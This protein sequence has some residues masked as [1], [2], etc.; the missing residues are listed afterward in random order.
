MRHWTAPA[1]LALL[2]GCAQRSLPLPIS[3]VGLDSMTKVHFDSDPV[4]LPDGGQ[5]L[6]FMTSA[7]HSELRVLNLD[8]AL[9][10]RD[11]IR[12][13][14]PIEPLAIPVLPEP[15]ALAHDTTWDPSGTEVAGPYVYARAAA[16]SEI[17]VVT[18]APSALVEY[19]RMEVSGIV[20]AIA[21]RAPDLLSPVGAGTTSLLYYAT[22]DDTTAHLYEVT[23]PPPGVLARY[24]VPGGD[25][26]DCA[27]DGS[28]AGGSGRTFATRPLLD[29]PG[30]S[31]VALLVLPPLSSPAPLPDGG[32][33]DLT[34]PAAMILPA[35]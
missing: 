33:F 15:V 23:M 1:A 18:D 5:D 32:V 25:H 34:P 28:D 14:N 3:I 10:P 2:A 29:L 12:A 26:I 6:L 4:F 21:A 20:T 8:P 35:G 24:S 19:C 13:P 7:D 11:F 27:G 31:I 30:E 16:G 17:S 22:W 9:N